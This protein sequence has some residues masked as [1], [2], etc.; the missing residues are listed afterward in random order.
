MNVTIAA[1]VTTRG[2]AAKLNEL[3]RYLFHLGEDERISF[4]ERITRSAE[5]IATPYWG[6]PGAVIM[7]IALDEIALDDA[8]LDDAALEIILDDTL[9][10][11]IMI[12]N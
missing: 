10:S 7:V 11:N 6:R 3:L 8:A 4:R 1:K 9:L 2:T 12:P 5:T